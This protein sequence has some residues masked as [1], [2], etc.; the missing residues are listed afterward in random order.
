MGVLLRRWL[1]ATPML[2]NVLLEPPPADAGLGDDDEP[3]LALVGRAGTATTRLAPAGKA[4]IDGRI[5]DVASDGFVE[6][7]TPVRVVAVRGGRVIVS[8]AAADGPA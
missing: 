1:P 6:A 7:G 4:R 3:D 8:A 5:V 2:R